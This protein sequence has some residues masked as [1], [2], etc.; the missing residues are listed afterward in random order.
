ML[1]PTLILRMGGSGEVKL[2]ILNL[3]KNLNIFATKILGCFD[4]LVFTT[5]M[6]LFWDGVYNAFLE[7]KH[8]F[9]QG[10]ITNTLND[11]E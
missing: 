9:R 11:Y 1:R 2:T 7:K 6:G 4:L 8:G 10:C 3:K 5:V